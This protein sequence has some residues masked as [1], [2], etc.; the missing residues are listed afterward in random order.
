VHHVTRTLQHGEQLVIDARPGMVLAD[1]DDHILS[2]YQSRIQASRERGTALR[3]LIK[4]P[5]ITIDGE[6]VQLMANIE[7][8]EEIEITRGLAADGVGLYRTE[9][10]YMNQTDAPDEEAHFAAYRQVVEG[11]NGIPITIR[12]LDLGADKPL[13]GRFN[14]SSPPGTNPALGLRAIR[15]CLK[16]PELFLPQLRAILRVAVLGPVRIMVPM[17]S[18]LQ[19]V[20]LLRE[21]L[22]EAMQSLSQ[23]GLPFNPDVAVGGM[24]EVPAAA[25]CADAF[26]QVLDFLSIG[27]NDL[28]QYCLAIDRLDDEVTYL[29][30]PL[31]PAVLRLIQ[32]VIDAGH[33][34]QTPVSMCGEMAGDPS[35]IPLLLG[36]GLREFNMQPGAL[37]EAKRLLRNLDATSL[38]QQVSELMSNLGQPESAML[39]DRL[40]QMAQ[41][42]EQGAT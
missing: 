39:L 27:T 40:C 2:H 30:D 21:M 15:L 4:Q 14:R 7:L 17:L 20:R 23:D 22:D 37:L 31:H 26:A 12:T 16:E 13:P 1:V 8:P 29:Y 33:R 28:I 6:R 32:L 18:G 42:T 25:L 3:A 9:Y 11:L 36:M 34:H 35:F 24:I 5:A 19:E 10:L 38:Q 41:Q